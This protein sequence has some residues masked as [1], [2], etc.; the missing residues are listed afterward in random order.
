M[1]KDLSFSIYELAGSVGDFGTIL[2]LALALRPLVLCPSAP[3]LLLFLGIWF[4]RQDSITAT[5][6][7]S[8]R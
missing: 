3:P 5:R 8:N 4:I 1:V 6:S 2:P 7:P